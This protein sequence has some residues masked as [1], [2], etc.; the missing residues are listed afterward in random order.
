MH[1]TQIFVLASLLAGSARADT[2]EGALNHMDK[3]GNQFKGMSASFINVKH[4]AIVPNA[5]ATATGTMK[6]KRSKPGELIGLID[7]ISPDKKT[8][9][10]NGQTVDIYLPNI[11][12]VQ[13]VDLGKHKVLLEQFFLFGFGTSRRDLEAAYAVTYG[14]PETVNSEATTRLELVSKNPDVVR[15]LSKFELWISDKSG[16]PVQQKFYEPSGDFNVFTYSGMKINPTLTD[17][18]FKS[19]YKGFKKEIINK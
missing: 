3:A 9:V 7:F 16:E 6:I 10:L 15:Q 18:S 11:K 5:D 2:L 4:T 13:E 1:S 12:T 19:P 14:G 17:S 8:V